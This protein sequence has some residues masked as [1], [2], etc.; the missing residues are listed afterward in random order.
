MIT[1]AFMTVTLITLASV[2]WWA[3]SNGK[4]TRQNELFT[5]AESAA[6]A[7]TETVVANLDF[8]W[9][10]N[11]ALQSASHYSTLA[12]PD[13]TAWPMKFQYSDGSGNN[14]VTGVTVALTNYY[15]PV[16]SLF[17]G[18][19][20]YKQPCSITSTA[21]TIGQTYSVSAT[22]QQ[23]VEAVIIPLF[24][25]A[26]FYNMNLEIDPGAGMAVNGPVFSNAGIWAGTPNVT[27]NST[28]SAAGQLNVSGTDPW[29]SGKTDSGTPLGNFLIQPLS[30]RDSL[31]LPI[32]NS[33]NNTPS[34]VEA[35]I[36]L[37]TNGMGA[38]NP[39]AYSTNGQVYLFNESDL[40]ISNSANGLSSSKGT[41]ITIWFQDNQQATAL[42]PV[43]QD[44]YMITNRGKGTII[45]TNYISPA[46][47]T[48][49]V[50]AGY[51]FVTNVQYYDFRELDTVQAVQVDVHNLN[52]WLTNT[53]TTGGYTVN[54]KSFHDNGH[55]IQSIYV[56]NHV[57]ATASQLPAVRMVNGAQLPNTVDPNGTG[58]IT[59]GLTVTTPQP[60][61]VEGNYNVQTA[62]S[63]AL[64]SFGT[65]NT[66]YTYPAALIADAITILSGNWSDT[67]AAYLAGGSLGSRATPSATT[68]NAA[69][70][71]GI[72]QS[73]NSNYSGGV[74]NFLRMEE[75]WTGVILQYNGSIAVMFP[76]QY[77]INFWPG[78]GSGPNVYNPPTRHWGFDY[79][80]TD[81]SKLPHISPKVFRL[82]RDAWKGY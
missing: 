51:S 46:N 60:I 63:S 26:I 3:A 38:P 80:F 74:E 48:N 4:V 68:V 59:S 77:A 24:Q 79:N 36:N 41:N 1:L 35:V 72:V 19:S 69:A 70:L 32:G 23:T 64:A 11:Q 18:L 62:S 39:Q 31:T 82:I 52:V 76:S 7:A 5:T 25:F 16:G 58:K 57:P 42:T 49:V 34:S 66:A 30:G 27:F 20:G 14:G 15:A 37:V 17:Q 13:Q 12:L 21:T 56:Y 40:I 53:A 10:G 67:G 73:T 29:A 45:T 28:V 81:P 43:T 78:T 54:K 71:E 9:T 65:T 6:D 75:D 47:T 33:T 22:V 2:M 8:D 44:F 61:Y 55:G 50:F